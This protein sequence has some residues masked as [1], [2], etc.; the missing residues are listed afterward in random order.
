MLLFFSAQPVWAAWVISLSC[1]LKALLSAIYSRTGTTNTPGS[2]ETGKCG[3]F[4]CVQLSLEKEKI[5]G[6]RAVS[7]MNGAGNPETVHPALLEA[8]SHLGPICLQWDSWACLKPG[9]PHCVWGT[10]QGARKLQASPRVGD[11][12]QILALG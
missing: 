7:V 1:F 6:T 10:G 12:A 11:D 8:L 2:E 9:V 5:L 4:V 3:I